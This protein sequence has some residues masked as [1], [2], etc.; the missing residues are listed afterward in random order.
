MAM[1]RAGDSPP[2]V[3]GVA[4]GAAA[5][6]PKTGAAAAGPHFTAA[7]ALY[8]SVSEPGRGLPRPARRLLRRLR[9]W[10]GLPCQARPRGGRP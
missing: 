10:A 9:M 8:V 2:S 5:L 3:L 6:R 1:T 7:I 4:D